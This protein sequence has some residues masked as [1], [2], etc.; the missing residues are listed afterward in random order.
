[1]DGRQ[2]QLGVELLRRAVD[3]LLG[4]RTVVLD[5]VG[6][7][8]LLAEVETQRRRLEAL[9]QLLVAEIDRQGVAGEFAR[10]TSANLLSS[11]LRVSPGEAKARV[12]RA[13]DLGPRRALT[14]EPL[15][16]I[17]PVT[18]DAVRAGEISSA[19]VA[20]IA[21]CLD[22]IPAKISHQVSDAA[23]TFLVAAARA[24]HPGQLRR[25]A[26]LLLARLD[27]DGIEPREQD[28]EHRRGFGLR[29]HRDG[30]STPLG[31]F[32]PELTAMWETVFDSL[33][34]PQPSGEGEPDTR[35]GEQRR[36]D[37]AAEVLSRVLRSG[38][39]PANGGVPVT[40]LAR[41]SISELT[42]GLGIAVTGQGTQISI[43]RLLQM[44]ADARIIPVILDDAGGI[45]G[46]GRERR[47]ASQGQRF[48][49]AAR[50]GGCCFPGCDRPASWT[51]VHHIRSWLDGGPTDLDNMCLLCRYHHRMFE[52]L[53]WEVFMIDA[54][55]WWRP[56]A[57]L[58]PE[59]KPIR[60]TTHHL[61][62]I[63]FGTVA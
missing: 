24:E 60:N 33:A 7:T 61:D 10:G 4:T 63:D 37:A 21:E 51:E 5:G 20:V 59:R 47:L 1:M 35:T 55:P 13:R 42:S 9:D 53:G 16:P 43:T 54:I 49:L 30:S 44:S 34:A 2:T 19:H 12:A 14:G 58:D 27:P 17:L 22:A 36:H 45:L 25:S 46:Y 32:S 57:W 26:A 52:A 3:T 41:T 28:A 15:E 40:I 8:S 31:R 48:A 50:D 18:A 62:D 11:L 6:L 39:L 29:K 38:T 23:E 56:P